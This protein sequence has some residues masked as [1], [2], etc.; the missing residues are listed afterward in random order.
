MIIKIGKKSFGSDKK[1]AI[2]AVEDFYDIKKEMD[3]LYEKLKEHK[4][5]IITYAKEALDGSDNATVT[6]EEGSKSIKVS[7]GWDIKIEDEAKLK[8]ILGERFDVLV[9]TETVLKPERRLKEMAVEDDGL[10]LCLSV[11]EKTPTLTV[12]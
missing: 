3:I 7:F 5:V 9:K 10:K 1:E 8:E 11:K 6:F 4:E 2:R 12:I